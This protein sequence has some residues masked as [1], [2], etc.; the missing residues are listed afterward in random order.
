MVALAV[1]VVAGLQVENVTGRTV[2]K[3]QTYHYPDELRKYAH[4][5]PGTKIMHGTVG[6]YAP[7]EWP[8]WWEDF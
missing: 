2:V 3:R 8:A 7:Q 6:R 5:H 4:T 1:V